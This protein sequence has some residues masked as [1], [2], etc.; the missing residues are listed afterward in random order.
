M[1]GFVQSGRFGVAF[2]PLTLSP[3]LWLDAA[4]AATITSSG[5]AVSAWADKSTAGRNVTQSTAAAKPAT[6][7]RTMNGLNVLDFD[8]GDLLISSTFTLAQPVTVAVVIQMD[9]N[10]SANTQPFGLAGSASPTVYSAG[11]VWS[12]YAGGVLASGT[13]TNT[14]ANQLTAVFN[15]SSSV[16]RLNGAQIASGNAGSTGWA[17]HTFNIGASSILT[18]GFNGAIAEVVVVPSVLSTG[19]RAALETYLKSKWGTP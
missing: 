17:S 8:G 10:G 6:G 2:T 15:G 5:G 12:T 3:V 4:D 14:S 13:A 16:L 7:T 18:S 9:T 19:D 1:S 11:S